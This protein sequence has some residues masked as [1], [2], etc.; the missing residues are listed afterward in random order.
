MAFVD[1]IFHAFL[2]DRNENAELH[3]LIKLYQLHKHSR[4][5]RKYK[6]EF[7]RFKFRTFLSLSK[8]TVVAELLPENMP[9]TIKVLVL[10]KRNG[11]LDKVRDYISNF[12]NQS[13]I[14]FYD[15]TCDDFIEVKSVSEGLEELCITEQEYENKFKIYDEN[16]YLLHLRQPTDSCFVNNH[17]EINLLAWEASID[18]QSVFDYYKA[19]TYMY[20]NLSKQEDECSLAMKQAFKESL[21][22]SARSYEH[23]K[24]VAHAY[25]SKRKCYLQETV[26]QVIPEL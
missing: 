6:N 11:I 14:N 4:T 20:S 25:I 23:M 1:Q 16:S 8:K 21:E 17:F 18:I 24:S 3:N 19:N 12:L 5:C 10:R 15:P 7:C 13:K 9:E 26:Y 2:L 22:R